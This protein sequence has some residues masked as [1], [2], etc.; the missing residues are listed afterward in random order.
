MIFYIARLGK[1]K[2][3]QLTLERMEWDCRFLN[4]KDFLSECRSSENE[5]NDSI[6]GTRLGVSLW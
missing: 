1:Q 6:W 5:D 2:E 4:E 3:L